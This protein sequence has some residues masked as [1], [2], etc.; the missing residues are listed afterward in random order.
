[1]NDAQIQQ[2]RRLALLGIL[3]Q[4]LHILFGITAIIGMLIA[5]THL[6]STKG[7]LY[8]SHLKWQLVTFW[9]AFFGYTIAVRLWMNT[10]IRWP[11]F[12]VA[13]FVTYRLAVNIQYWLSEQPI[14]RI[15]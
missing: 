8:Y 7:T 12:V 5:H 2:S 10:D 1:V 6:A 3:L 4:V 14:D 13:G 11:V 9:C 15:L